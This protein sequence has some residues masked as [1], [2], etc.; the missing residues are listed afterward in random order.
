MNIL[1]IIEKLKNT[2]PASREELI[3]LLKN[4]NDS[5]R[6]VLRKAA[7]ERALKIFGN[8]IYIRGLIELPG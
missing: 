3:L 5:E 1:N 4:I 6:E 7:Q 8:K 2:N